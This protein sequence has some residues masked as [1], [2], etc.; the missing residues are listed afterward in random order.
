GLARG[1][2]DGVDDGHRVLLIRIRVRDA[3][4]R[5]GSPGG[6]AGSPRVA[7]PCVR[8]AIF[9]WSAVTGPAQPSAGSG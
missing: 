2:P 6:L 1:D 8:S 4:S 5:T 3:L 9:P 7:P